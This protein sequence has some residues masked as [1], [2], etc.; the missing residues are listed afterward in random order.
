MYSDKVKVNERPNRLRL[1]HG[2]V[3][4]RSEYNDGVLRNNNRANNRLSSQMQMFDKAQRVIMFC[5]PF[6]V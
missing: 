5:L 6:C 1:K 4:I 3:I 2:D